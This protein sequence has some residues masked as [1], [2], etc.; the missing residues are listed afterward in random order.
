MKTIGVTSEGVCDL[1]SGILKNSEVSIINFYIE[2]DSGVFRDVEEIS[3]IN[4]ISYIAEGG[5]KTITSEPSVEDYK[6]FF[7]KK[8]LEYEKIIHVS[9]S[10]LV[11]KGHINASA[12]VK[13][14]GLAGER[15]YVVDSKHLSSGIGMVVLEA[16]K[17]RDE[18]KSADEIVKCLEIMRERVNTSF[19][20]MDSNYLYRNGRVSERVETFC[21]KYSAHPILYLNKGWMKLKRL[22]FGNYEKACEKYIKS[23]LRKADRIDTGRL[24]ITHAGCSLKT[25]AWVKEQVKKYVDFEEVI[26][27]DATA[28]IS[29]NCGP[30]CFG[31]IF[32][33]KD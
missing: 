16:V 9:I 27:T 6:E 5:K 31:L 14:M 33:S 23:E 13:E 24:F 17:L 3:T 30:G 2:T 20:T 10:P 12:A 7:R 29:S 26:V 22:S 11:S 4:L 19:I 32:L 18:G 28:T 21:E 1:T 25:I 8:L 15:V